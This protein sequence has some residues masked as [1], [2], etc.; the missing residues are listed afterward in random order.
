MFIVDDAIDVNTEF[1]ADH[2][3]VVNVLHIDVSIEFVNIPD[4]KFMIL[5]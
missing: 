1:A 5:Q 4:V 3:R 2:K